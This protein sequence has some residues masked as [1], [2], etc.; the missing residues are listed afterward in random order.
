MKQAET[1]E[2]LR[3]YICEEILRDN[4][5]QLDE[6][7]PLISGGLIDSFSFISLAVFVEEEFSL[8]IP[9]GDLTVE[10][11]DTLQCMAKYIESR[12]S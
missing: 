2:L 4:D 6:N 3:A 1:L 10:N 9:D 7:Q 12:R 11:L 8:H 5:F